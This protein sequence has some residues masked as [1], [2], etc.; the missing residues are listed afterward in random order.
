[1]VR[2]DFRMN[3]KGVIVGSTV[4][5]SDTNTEIPLRV[6]G[7]EKESIFPQHRSRARARSMG[8]GYV[9]LLALAGC[10]CLLLCVNYLRVRSDLQSRQAAVDALET[11]LARQKAD[12]DE[13]QQQV[14]SAMDLTR[15]YRI[16]TTQLGMVYPEEGQVLE[17]NSTDKEFVTQEGEIPKS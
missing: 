8:L 13:I 14:D 4:V 15:I 16:A 6:V 5:E 10:I 1:M 3:K 2:I 12:N 11:Q 7:G 17:Y 9:F